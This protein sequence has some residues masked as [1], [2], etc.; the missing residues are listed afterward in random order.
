M[1]QNKDYLYADLLFKSFLTLR[2]DLD[3][4]CEKAVSKKERAYAMGRLA[5]LDMAI[6]LL[7]AYQAEMVNQELELTSNSTTKFINKRYD[8]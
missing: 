4:L 5:G 1:K 3:E 8:G 7:E 6:S 2:G